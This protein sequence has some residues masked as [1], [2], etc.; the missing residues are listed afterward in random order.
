[1]KPWSLALLQPLTV[2]RQTQGSYC[3]SILPLENMLFHC[4][5]ESLIA[6]HI[7]CLCAKRCTSHPEDCVTFVG[8]WQWP[9]SISCSKET[10]NRRRTNCAKNSSVASLHL[11]SAS[12][13]H[14]ENRNS[15]CLKCEPKTGYTVKYWSTSELPTSTFIMP[16]LQVGRARVCTLYAISGPDCCS[17]STV[18]NSSTYGSCFQAVREFPT[19][20]KEPKIWSVVHC[21]QSYPQFQLA[22]THK[23]YGEALSSP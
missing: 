20:P 3:G 23:Q 1:M 17:A 10:K 12:F 16:L 5:S 19:E 4:S 8:P 18:R 11:A 15:H 13:K 14:R 22:A 6:I 9:K 7:S 21:K 2:K